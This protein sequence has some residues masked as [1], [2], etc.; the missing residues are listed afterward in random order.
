MI[1]L[2]R[3]SACWL[4]PSAFASDSSVKITS[5]ARTP[6]IARGL[7]LNVPK[8]AIFPLVTKSMYFFLPPKAA[9][10]S[11]PPIDFARV[12]KSGVTPKRWAAP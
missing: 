12:I 3:S 10:V 6:A 9:K 11:P 1:A 4:K 2:M 8:W 7:P 5:A